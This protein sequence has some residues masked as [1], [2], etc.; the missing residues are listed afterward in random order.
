MKHIENYE[1]RWYETNAAR[2]LR[3]S[4]LLALMQETANLQ[5]ERAGRS[6]DVLR[7]E[8]GLA[9]ILGRLALDMPAPLF[10]YDRVSVATFTCPSH[11]YGFMRGF[12]VRRGDEVV[13]RGASQWAL[14]DVTTR[15]MTPVEKAP[16]PFEDEPLEKTQ[17]PL[18]FAAPADAAFKPVGTRAVAY[19]DID[20]NGH[21]NNA[22]YP[23]MVCDFLPDPAGVRVTGLSLSYVKE[24]PYGSLLTVERADCGGGAYHFRARCGEAVCLDALVHTEP[25]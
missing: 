14:L 4:A 18:R 17:M 16:V 8:K 20:Y 24:A 25:L 12:E 21:M 2:M 7:D 23:D 9:F 10:A 1:V 11:G 5:F 13:A 3:P 15:R 22:R 19:A 6:L